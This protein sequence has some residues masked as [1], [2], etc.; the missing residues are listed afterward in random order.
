M[1]EGQKRTIAW[2][3]GSIHLPTDRIDK[4]KGRL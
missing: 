4:V 3:G 2:Q 1:E